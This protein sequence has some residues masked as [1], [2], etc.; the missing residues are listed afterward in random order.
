MKRAGHSLR[1]V[2]AALQGRLPPEAEW[3]AVIETANRGW[4]GPALYVALSRNGSLAEA[5]EPVRDYLGLLHERNLERNRRLRAQ[6]TEAVIAL[7][8]SGIQP[9]LL[10]GAAT[11]FLRTGDGLGGRMMSDLDIGIG[12][13][14]AGEAVQ[15]L[16]SLGYRFTDEGH[17]ARLSDAGAI[18]LHDRPNA[19]SARYLVGDLRTCSPK[20][21]RDG[22]VARLPSPTARAIHLIVHD[23]IKEGD[24]WRLGINPRHLYDLAELVSAA[25]GLDWQ[26]LSETLSDTAG[27]RA[28]AVQ[29]TALRDLFGVR[30][31]VPVDSCSRAIV[32]LKHRARL[33]VGGGGM[34]AALLRTWGNLSWGAHC[35][36][37]GFTWQGSS[38]FA[39]RLRA[40][41]V[42][43][44]KGSSL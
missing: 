28:L 6:L 12:P 19:R 27:R 34:G 18:D 43:G 36:A 33:V 3:P 38:D 16:T 15:A 29:A 11:L 7:N 30:M 2:S 10:K 44:P 1:L 9:I 41:L 23:M 26:A 42:L 24:Y 14:E 25:E 8:S 13:E 40:V 39:R 37:D 35:F 4:L 31:P 21:E 17:L 20:V 5:P 32:G 22:A